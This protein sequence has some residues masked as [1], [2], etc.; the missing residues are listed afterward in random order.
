MTPHQFVGLIADMID[1][2]ISN[3]FEGEQFFAAMARR[4]YAQAA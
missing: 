2:E 3:V 1:A 4:M